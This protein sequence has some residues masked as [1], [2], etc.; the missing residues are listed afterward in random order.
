MSEDSFDIHFD[1]PL[2]PQQTI[3]SGEE[4]TSCWAASAAMIVA[5]R[6]NMSVDPT[7]IANLS[8]QWAAYAEGITPRDIPSLAQAWGLEMSE[9]RC[10]SIED[11]RALIE[12]KG[13]LWVAMAVPGGHVV[14]IAGIYGDGTPDGTFVRVNDPWERDT[15]D[16]EHPGDYCAEPGNGSQYS[17]GLYQFA[18]QF[19]TLSTYPDVDIQVLNAPTS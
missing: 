7:E 10:F 17:I 15:T 1:V 9:P 16:K 13:P 8:G 11:L 6:Y 19:E 5:W 3:S 4:S 12:S 2:I 14:V 18:S